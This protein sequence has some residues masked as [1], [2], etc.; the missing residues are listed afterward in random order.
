MHALSTQFENLFVLQSSWSK[1]AVEVDSPQPM[2]P[3]DDLA[4]PPDSTCAQVI[5]S[6]PE[7]H[8]SNWVPINA[9]RK[10]ERQDEETGRT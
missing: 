7:A 10:S 5:H 9:T 4:E 3:W 1:R 2:S 8:S 6:R